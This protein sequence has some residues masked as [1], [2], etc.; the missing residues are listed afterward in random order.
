MVLVVAA[1]LVLVILGIWWVTRKRGPTGEERMELS[2]AENKVKV[3]DPITRG[4]IDVLERWGSKLLEDAIELRR[5]QLQRGDH[6][7]QR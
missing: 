4:D 7:E 2:R 3:S 1:A 6:P 5:A